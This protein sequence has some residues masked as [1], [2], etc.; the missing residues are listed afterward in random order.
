[1]GLHGWA[2]GEARRLRLALVHTAL[3]GNPFAGQ[4]FVF[5][6]RRGERTIRT[7][8]TEQNVQLPPSRHRADAGGNKLSRTA[9]FLPFAD[10]AIACSVIS[11]GRQGRAAC[12][13]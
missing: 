8:R 10:S 12:K 6:G 2:G 4:V 11:V 7:Q 5:R 13:P 1:M 9:P 3:E